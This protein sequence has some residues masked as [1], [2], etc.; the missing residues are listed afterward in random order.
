M[1]II[2]LNPKKRVILINFPKSFSKY[3]INLKNKLFQ[4]KNLKYDKK[5]YKIFK[6]NLLFKSKY[7]ITNK[8][9]KKKIFLKV[10]FPRKFQIK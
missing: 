1:T 7:K 3:R 4:K 2:I 10:S 6:I 8:K 5:V 9:M